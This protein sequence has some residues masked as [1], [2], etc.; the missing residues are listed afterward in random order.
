[1]R[2]FRR[3]AEAASALNHPNILTVYEVGRWLSRDF[4]ATEYIEGAT[5]RTRM[6]GRPLSIAA[7]IDIALQ[8]SSALAAAHGAGIVHRDIKPENVMVRPDGLVKVLDFGIAKFVEPRRDD[9]L[10]TTETVAGVVVGTTAYMS[11]E[12]AQGLAVDQRS[13]IWSLGVVI[14]EMITRHLPFSGDTGSDRVTAIQAPDPTSL[15]RWR[16][17]AP[18]E[19]ERILGRALARNP[20]GRYSSVADMADDLRK[21]RSTLTDQ[22]L[23]H[24]AWPAPTRS[25]SFLRQHAVFALAML[26]VLVTGVAF[27]LSRMRSSTGA[28]TIESL[29]ILPLDNVEGSS[30]IDYLSDG[31]T[32]SLINDLAKLPDLKVMSQNSVFRYKGRQTDA[33]SVGSALHV[34]AVLTGRVVQRGEKVSVGVELVKARDGSRLWGEQYIRPL[35]ELLALQQE[36]T[37]DV[38]RKL[39]SRISSADAARL[40][41]SSVTN[42][43]A[44][45]DYLKGRYYVRKATRPEIDT[46]IAY[47]RQAIDIDPSYAL[48]YVGLADAYRV[49]AIAGETPATEELPKAKAAAEKAVAIDDTLAEGHA[50]LG[51]VIF[52]YDW[53]W[54]DAEG[55]CKHAVDLDPNSADAH[56][57]YAHVLSYTG[58]HAEAL[59]E[60]R[61]AADLD[62]LNVRTGALEGAFLINA[63]RADEASAKLEKTL[64]LEPNYWFARQYAASAFIERGMF[65]EAVAEARRAKQLSGVSTRPTAFLGY[66]LARS[67][68]QAEARSELDGLLRL[69]KERYVSPYN[70]AMIYHGL[71]QREETLA[72]LERGY[73]E[74]EPRMVFLESEPK[75]NSLRGDPRFPDLLRRIGFTP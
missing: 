74:R 68:R 7:A 69:S 30:D 70:I 60:I 22:T 5:L 51:F 57:A 24:I 6:R 73:R 59:A 9:A 34:Q 47:F 42:Q 40:A 35:T 19:L 17:D 25:V 65:A 38:S 56:E 36:V 64:E 37:R 23:F 21:L 11:P 14:F 26:L 62:P 49:L 63:G 58:R 66:A 13:D 27:G 72:W 71:G 48:A 43:E 31:I 45:R 32:E 39:R 52:W 8:I 54:G 67:G 28:A 44:Y 50:I 4:I 29:A 33:A 12:Q 55:E 10:T 16:R 3:E 18:A 75:W 41:K 46:G 53:K 2:R 20:D 15:S 1:V 61:R